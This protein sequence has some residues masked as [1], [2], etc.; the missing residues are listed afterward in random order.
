MNEQEQDDVIPNQ[1]DQPV[2]G[3]IDLAKELYEKLKTNIRG[4]SERYKHVTFPDNS[5]SRFELSIYDDYPSHNGPKPYR[6]MLWTYYYPNDDK[7]MIPNDIIQKGVSS[8]IEHIFREVPEIVDYSDDVLKEFTFDLATETVFYKEGIFNLTHSS[9]LP[10]STT[11]VLLAKYPLSYLVR[12]PDGFLDMYLLQNPP[13]F[14]QTYSLAMDK[15]IKRANTIYKAF[16]KG[17]W[18]GLDYEFM[19][20][21]TITIHQKFKRYNKEQRVLYPDFGVSISSSWPKIDGKI[22]RASEP[23]EKQQFDEFIKDMESKFAVFGIRF[24]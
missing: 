19:Y 16:S 23:E 8:C 24:S 3:T 21:P 17:K 12:R 14:D 11:N 10:Q 22:N 20:S 9:I 18:R 13:T 6:L 5:Y 7:P 2:D 4:F 15:I 1:G